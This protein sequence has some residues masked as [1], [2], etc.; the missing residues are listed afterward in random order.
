MERVGLA[1]GTMIGGYRIL[2]P[3]GSGAMGAVYRARDADGMEV[4]MKTLHPSVIADAEARQRLQRE[5]KVLSRIRHHGVARVIDAE[6]DGDEMF[7]V[8]ELIEGPTLE[9]EIDAGG[10]LGAEDLFNLADQL[11]E[12]L[13]AVHAAGV[14][15]RDLKASNVLISAHGPVL[16]DFGIAQAV[17]DARVTRTGL[18]MGTPAY[19]APE[20]VEGAEP[21]MA[22]DWWG[23]AAMIAFAATGRP[24]FGVRPID[25][26]LAR[27]RSGQVDL[28]GLGP[29]TARALLGALNPH[30]DERT[31]PGVVVE[32][33]RLAWLQGDPAVLPADAATSVVDAGAATAVIS[34][35][36]APSPVGAAA[37]PPGAGQSAPGVIAGGDTRVMAAAS[38]G[39]A[40][41]DPGAAAS[42][43]DDGGAEADADLVDEPAEFYVRPTVAHRTWATLALGVPLLVAAASWPGPVLIVFGIA[44]LVF[45]LVGV[46]F[47]SVHSRR[48]ARGGI[49]GSDGVVQ[50]LLAPWLAIRALV[51]AVPAVLVT[52]AGL[53]PT[54]G[55][56]WW[57]LDNHKVVVGAGPD[58]DPQAYQW[59]LLGSAV[60]VFVLM[61]FGP[62]TGLTRLGARIVV[63]KVIP[64]GWGTATAW[65]VSALVTFILWQLMVSSHVPVWAPFPGPPHLVW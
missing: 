24:P 15:H 7:I 56:A 38:A 2:A 43:G 36:S 20:L 18:V 44:W 23:W 63:N 34:P 3:L 12:A 8:T 52:I 60:V 48:E 11:Y 51:G 19:L 45:R 1:P 61:W 40:A 65:V 21:S 10:K 39:L 57:M 27:A 42:A 13:T 50:G 64:R 16:I 30:P 28:A 35:T 46:V 33:L 22:T 62:L 41:V 5:I 47:D 9:E 17:G 58:S 26:V 53:L 37:A 49:S 31:P 4:A 54:G 55:L 32:Q 29:R 6:A 59:V 25:A 14:I